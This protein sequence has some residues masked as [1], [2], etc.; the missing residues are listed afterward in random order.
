[1]ILTALQSALKFSGFYLL[2]VIS[3]GFYGRIVIKAIKL[4]RILLPYGNPFQFIVFFSLLALI[5]RYAHIITNKFDIFFAF[6]FILGLSGFLIEIC[7]LC[8]KFFREKHLLKNIFEDVDKKYGLIIVSLISSFI[9]GLYFSISTISKTL[10]PWSATNLD[11]YSWLFIS[12]YWRG[13]VNLQNY[14][15]LDFDKWR[16]DA[17]GADIF[18]GY[19]TSAYGKISLMA[20]PALT[21]ALLSLISVST[22]YLTRSISN[23]PIYLVLLISLGLA[24]GNFYNFLAFYGNYG[25]LFSL[26]G[27]IVAIWVILTYSDNDNLKVKIISLFFPIL[28]LFAGYQAAFFVFFVILLFIY[29]IQQ[30]LNYSFEE[31]S[32][33]AVIRYIINIKLLYIF[34]PLLIS[35]I[36]MPLVTHQ[37]II[38]IIQAASQIGMKPQGL[39]DPLNFTGIP[40]IT[41]GFYLDVSDTTPISYLFLL[42][43]VIILTIFIFF[44][45]SNNHITKKLITNIKCIAITFITCI[46]LYLLFYKILGDTYQVFKFAGYAILPISFTLPVLIFVCLK[47]I[48]NKNKLLFIIVSFSVIISVVSIPVIQITRPYYPNL[49]PNKY[50]SPLPLIY[51]L[52]NKIKDN[53]NMSRIIFDF[54]NEGKSL[55]AALLSESFKGKI[56]F[57]EGVYFIPTHNDFLEVFDE[58]TV[59]YTDKIFLGLYGGNLQTGNERFTLNRYNYTDLK[60]I[61]AVSYSGIYAFNYRVTESI[62]KLKIIV[63]SSLIG[64]KVELNIKF[65]LNSSYDELCNQSKARIIYNYNNEFQNFDIN[66]IKLIVSKSLTEAGVIEAEIYFPGLQFIS[67]NNNK[68]NRNN[69]NL[70]CDYRLEKV[71]LNPEAK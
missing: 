14:S 36:I 59:L 48:S 68:I 30:L 32:F 38:R 52:S 23:L 13:F 27:F 31:I 54:T 3:T 50:W 64:S 67:D 65:N 55:T 29:L 10:E 28:Y 8:L 57:V 34:I 25:H 18:L 46:I 47:L 17:F 66:S 26:I 62:V 33:I 44:N 1:M 9:F 40:L 71:W 4:D 51:E 37:A 39:I 5:C 11:Y 24:G 15:I 20:S 49:R 63:P 56:D 41:N 45:K 12:D 22:Y 2:L 43:S 61:G 58:N 21:A 42:L 6:L 16:F 35:I 70:L 69:Q 19:F 60:K 53:N 7:L